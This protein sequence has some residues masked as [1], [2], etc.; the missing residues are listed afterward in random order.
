[1]RQ[2]KIFYDTLFCGILTETDDGEF[3]F[4][5]DGDYVT[6]GFVI[7][8]LSKLHRCCKCSTNTDER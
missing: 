1:M 2:A 4:K 3:T 7:S 6:H 8:L 5:Y